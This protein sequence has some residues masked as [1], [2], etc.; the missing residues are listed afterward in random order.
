MARR[1]GWFALVGGLLALVGCTR[2]PAPTPEQKA[3]E[4]KVSQPVER[5]VVDYELFTGKT[6][7]SNTTDLRARVTG[8]L[9]ATFFT[10]G[11]VVQK[12]DLLFRI[13]QRPYKVD[14]DKAKANLV[15]AKAMTVLTES[16]EVRGKGLLAD[17]AI[18]R[19]DYEKLLA[20]V[21][22]ARA[23][24]LVAQAALEQAELNMTWTEVRAPITGRISRW[25]IDTG[26]LIKAD[27]TILATLV[28][29]SPTYVL[30]DVDERT[31]LREM[32]R[33]GLTKM[34]QREPLRVE[35][36]LVDEPGKYPHPAVINFVDNR[37]DSST[38][39]LWMRATLVAPNR[40]VS[41]GLF[42][43]V[44]FPLGPASPAL[45]VAEAALGTD[46]G[47]RFVFVVDSDDVVHYRKVA[48]GRQHGG[49]RVVKSGLQAGE[50]IVVS[51]LQR[52]RDGVKV[53]PK[54]VDMPGQQIE[55]PP[56]EPS[57]HPHPAHPGEK[58]GKT[59]EKDGKTK[60]PTPVKKD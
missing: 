5:Q 28:S 27:D 44:R 24:V 50:R 49:L 34:P 19:E 43:R 3:P 53:R 7:A 55:T 32:V 42:S 47:Q 1:A 52:V 38:G 48:V 37:L 36:G 45:C 23:N 11:T 25:N 56:D 51:G 60:N 2:P 14:L 39:S 30:F 16:I 6:V 35:V 18:S 22:V 26:N 21:R 58:D 57:D 15:S 59:N 12:D 4:V 40:E 31:V 8:Y 10:E 29:L 33:A 46:Q 54:P 17:R 9:D 13:D 41:P 20:D